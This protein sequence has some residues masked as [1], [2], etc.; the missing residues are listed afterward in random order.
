MDANA[1]NKI[2]C[3]LK[4]T[5]LKVAVLTSNPCVEIHV[6]NRAN[7]NAPINQKIPNGNNHTNAR[8][9]RRNLLNPTNILACNI[10]LR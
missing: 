5:L 9:A 1:I 4:G 2:N 6:M 3:P 7:T 10:N 8:I